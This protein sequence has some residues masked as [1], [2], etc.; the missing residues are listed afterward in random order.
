MFIQSQAASVFWK[1]KTIILSVCWLSAFC[2]EIDFSPKTNSGTPFAREISP[3]IFLTYVSQIEN[4]MP[5]LH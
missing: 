5:H 2:E 4:K 1:V 3:S